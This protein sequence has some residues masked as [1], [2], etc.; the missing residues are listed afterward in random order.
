MERMTLRRS[1]D[2]AAAAAAAAAVGVVG[3]EEDVV[4]GL[5]NFKS[6][7]PPAR[8]LFFA[9]G[10]WEDFPAELLKALREAF[11]AEK[12]IVEVPAGESLFLFDFARMLQIDPS[13]CAR[14]PIAWIDVNGRC[15][16]PRVF[17]GR[18]VNENGGGAA[19]SERSND[20]EAMSAAGDS[21]RQ[22]WESLQVLSEGDRCYKIVRSLFLTG[23]RR[24]SPHTRI[25]RIRRGLRLKAF[26][27]Q[28]ERTKLAGGAANIKFGW[29]GADASAVAAVAADG[30]GSPIPGAFL[31]HASYPYPSS[32]LSEV[33]E[34]G[35]RHIVL[36]KVIMRSPEK[37]DFSSPQSHPGS[38]AAFV[39]GVDDL[40]KPRWDLVWGAQMNTNILPQYIVSF[41]TSDPQRPMTKGAKGEAVNRGLSFPKL[42]AEM[43]SS[44]PSSRVQ[45]LQV[46]YNR[47]KAGRVSKDIFTAGLRRIVGDRLLRTAI[48][49]CNG[50]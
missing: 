33:D 22:R 49:R 31:S 38:A 9:G 40:E 26:M 39:C 11:V 1:G 13:T 24:F 19:P 37:V 4:W 21:R 36:C 32:L 43:G 30:F 35:E 6:S 42:F 25:T 5:R 7:A 28:A 23:M 14:N 3:E 18:G 46:L 45:A 10:Y 16:F 20:S 48:K 12:A 34:D 47:F 15:F 29:Y 2:V 8:V 44:L 17:V 50:R 27:A 41:K